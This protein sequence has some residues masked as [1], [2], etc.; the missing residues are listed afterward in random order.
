MAK[1]NNS[2]AGDLV[3]TAVGVGAVVGAGV[4]AA[5]VLSDKEKRE[6]V[7]EA[8]GKVKEKGEE[9][10]GA[11]VEKGKEAI[12]NAMNAAGNLPDQLRGEFDE[13]RKNIEG[14]VDDIKSSPAAKKL[15]KQ[16]EDL[17]EVFAKA[18]DSGEEMTEKVAS[19]IRERIDTL[20]SDYEDAAAESEKDTKAKKI[21]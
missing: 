19:N 5:K 15:Q 18:K 14:K 7:G 20:R 6:Q 16:I 11:V 3:K 4:L 10:I 9:V 8:L 13:L 17:D 2:G 1:N 12:E 21:N